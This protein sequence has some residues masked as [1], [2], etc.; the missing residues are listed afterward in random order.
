MK[1]VISYIEKKADWK[2]ELEKLREA[3]LSC[4][5]EEAIKWGAPVYMNKGKNILGLSAFKNY[6]GLWFF[7]G[8]TLK[9]TR[10]LLVNAQ[11]GKTNAM[12][13]WRF[14]SIE[15]INSQLIVDY[16]LEAIDNQ[17]SGNI[18]KPNKKNAKPIVIHPL[19]QEALSVNDVLTS[20]FEELGLTKKRE[21]TD[22]IN[23]AKREATQL[24][25][26][27]KII[28]MILNGVG[29]YDKYKNC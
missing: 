15:E 9:D 6:V 3:V 7:Q 19:F 20:K 13:Q 16:I 4:G 11:E 14:H 23:E 26:L 27:E 28:P 10:N 12:R 2:P 24:K 22:Y 5:L 25:R 17:E 18:I 29:L 1:E 8:G 21:F